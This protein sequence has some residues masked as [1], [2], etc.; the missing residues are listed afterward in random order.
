MSLLFALVACQSETVAP[1]EPVFVDPPSVPLPPLV[2]LDA[3]TRSGTRLEAVAWEDEAGLVVQQGFFDTELGVHCR[4]V[5]SGPSTWHCLPSG[6][7]LGA[8]F[9][10]SSCEGPPILKIAYPQCDIAPFDSGWKG[11]PC[12]G[13]VEV[14]QAEAPTSVDPDAS[15]YTLVD[16]ECEAGPYTWGIGPV[17]TATGPIA[18]AIFVEG[19]PAVASVDGDAFAQVVWG[20]DGSRAVLNAATREGEWCSPWLTEDAG[21][22]CLPTTP[23]GVG[24]LF[25]DAGCTVRLGESTGGC[26]P[27]R[28]ARED[29]GG[30]LPESRVLRLW[31]FD[32]ALPADAPVWTLVGDRCE[33]AQQSTGLAYHPIRDRVNAAVFPIAIDRRVGADLRQE[34]TLTARDARIAPTASGLEYRGERCE[35]AVDSVSG[36]AWCV[37]DALELAAMDWFADDACTVPLV[38]DDEALVSDLQARGECDF[39]GHPSVSRVLRAAE[40]H[41]GPAWRA[42]G[43]SCVP[44][45][46]PPALFALEDADL[47]A[48]AR[49]PFP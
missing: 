40:P 8:A 12:E 45:P 34:W 28:F 33:P 47:P 25:G 2:E 37:P 35:L 5:P 41:A 13:H 4:F 15:P 42:V 32:A 17:W 16:G 3:Y 10:D 22:R 39:D 1:V 38:D 31:T 44:D 20:E 19:T 26:G 49:V 36:D 27:A 30:G 29:L 46:S 14:Y 43:G 23:V 9:A 21:M 11:T 18:P 48:L 24:A 6:T 7:A